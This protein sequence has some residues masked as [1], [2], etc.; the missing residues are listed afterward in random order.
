MAFDE[1]ALMRVAADREQIAEYSPA[2]AASTS[3]NPA[4]VLGSARVDRT[5]RAKRTV[6][7]KSWGP[8]SALR[9]FNQRH[10]NVALPAQLEGHQGGPPRRY[11]RSI[12]D[13]LHRP[14]RDREAVPAGV[15]AR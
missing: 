1:L 14:F 7:T 12:G 2:F 11:L 3:S 13:P 4:P 5:S 9:I 8:L 6:V 15:R 10:R